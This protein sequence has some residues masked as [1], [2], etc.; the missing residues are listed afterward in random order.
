MNHKRKVLF[1]QLPQLD[2]DTAGPSE[3]LMLAAAYLEHAADASGES[4]YHR[5]IRL[6]P[7]LDHADTPALTNAILHQKPNIIAATLYLW[8]I[9]WTLRLLRRIKAIRPTTKIIVGGPEVARRHPF[10]YRSGVPDVAVSGE[11]EAVFPAILK[12]FRLGRQPDFTTVAVNT[13]H[14]Y[15][16]GHTPPPSVTLSNV[17]PP[18]ENS[19][20]APDHNGMAYMETSRGCPMRCA[21]CRYAH[22]RRQVSFLEPESV[23]AR[24]KA[25]RAMGAREIRFV[26]PT[27]NAHPHF[28]VILR[29]LAKLNRN[30]PVRF[31]AE[32]IAERLTPEDARLLAAA[33]FKDIE[34]GMQ[35]R[36]REV[37]RAI[38]RPTRL[39]QLDS[40]IQLLSRHGI[41]VTLDV[42]YALPLQDIKGVRNSIA[43]SLRQP[44]TNIQCLQTLLL[45]GTELRDRR[46]EW[47]FK[48]LSLPPYAVTSTK[49]L[50]ATDVVRIENWIAHHPRLRS[51]NPTD[52][53]IGRKLAGLFDEQISLD[54]A[55]LPQATRPGRENRRTYLIHGSNLFQHR[56]SLARFIR[57]CIKEQPDG[58]FQFVLV[59]HV[60]EPLD[61]LDELLA[62]IR[63][64]PS[65]LVDRY[66]GIMAKN[67]ITSR[68]IRILLPPRQRF[69]PQWIQAAEQVLS[70]AFF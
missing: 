36:D 20:C 62:V 6:P 21:Y 45:P 16:W 64:S 51:D 55:S 50:S 58:L 56:T 47:Q 59:P 31:F 57:R 29:E 9:E 13:H 25:L 44:K 7:A 22:L 40:G 2:N 34:V 37:L 26:D 60:E 43:W 1:L 68:R 19:A 30:H 3:N 33:N 70:Q 32:L 42:M 53:F 48:A 4:R 49:S 24:I 18:I 38:H 35:S 67:R 66:A 11:G 61:L 63:K 54:A 8:N 41:K 65:H 69:D 27:F 52:R 10:L 39:A 46:L 12:A 17:L 5:F 28:Q 23:V 15:R 14:G